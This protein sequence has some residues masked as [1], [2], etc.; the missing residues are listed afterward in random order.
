VAGPTS[1][2]SK[3]TLASGHRPAHPRG[4]QPHPAPHG[5]ADAHTGDERIELRSTTAGAARSESSHGGGA[6]T[7]ANSWRPTSA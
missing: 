1:L 5:V 7:G 3:T 4:P 2:V 6:G